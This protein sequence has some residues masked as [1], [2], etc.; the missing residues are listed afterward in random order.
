[1]AERLTRK[2]QKHPCHEFSR[3]VIECVSNHGIEGEDCVRQ[4]LLE[5]KCHAELLC[6]PEAKR[7]YRDPAVKVRPWTT[8]G[9]SE[10]RPSCSTLLEVFAF[11]E[12]EMQISSPMG[13]AERAE[14]RRIVH[15]LAKCMSRH[16]V[17]STNQQH[18]RSNFR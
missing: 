11:P 16:R 12:N 13:K 18:S 2:R 1:M 8:R 6:R 15:D 7:F 17:A 4:E 14:C 10:H 3:S 9:S 5:K